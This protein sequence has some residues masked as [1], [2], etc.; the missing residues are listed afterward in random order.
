MSLKQGCEPSVCG[1]VHPSR[2]Q[3]GLVSQELDEA[4]P[5]AKT[6]RVTSLIGRCESQKVVAK[7]DSSER[8]ASLTPDLSSTG[9]GWHFHVLRRTRESSR[10]SKA[11]A[12]L[13]SVMQGTALI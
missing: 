7:D 1:L 10:T 8:G 2:S 12:F 13:G 11:P 5:E 9:H 6:Q 4:S 3:F